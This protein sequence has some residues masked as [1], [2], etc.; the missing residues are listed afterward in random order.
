MSFDE[1]A[2]VRLVHSPSQIGVV[3]SLGDEIGGRRYSL[4][5]F[6]DGNRRI[7]EDQLELIPSTRE[8]PVD[9]LANG[10]FSGPDRYRQ[11]LTYI[12]LTGK[13][14]D[15]VYSMEASNT[16][17]YPYQF[18]PVLKML[19]SPTGGLLIADEVGLGKTIEAGLIWMELR[20]RFDLRRLLVICPLS[21]REKWQLELSSRFGIDAQ[22]A[23][24]AELLH[25]LE[26]S[27]RRSRGFAAI[28][29]METVLPPRGWRDNEDDTSPRARLARLLDATSEAE[30]L[31]DLLVIDEAHH[32]RNP[33]TARHQAGVLLRAASDY[34]LFLSATPIHLRNRDL[35]ALLSLLD[36]DTFSR[37]NEFDDI[38]SA[39]APLV[40]ARDAV[41]S[42]QVSTPELVAEI[43]L[44][45]Q[46]DLLSGSQQ[47][48]V[49]L[50][51]L[52]SRGTELDLSDRARIAFRLEQANLLAHV[53]SRTRRR[54][55][56]ELRIV[57]NVHDLRIEFSAIERLVY[58]AASHA[59]FEYASTRA[60][61]ERFLQ[62]TPQRLLSSSIAAAV[63]HWQR[64][65]PSGVEEAD[66]DLGEEWDDVDELEDLLEAFVN[67]E[68]GET[69]R[70]DRPLVREL[71]S[72]S[73]SLVDQA[74]LELN[75]SKFAKLNGFLLEILATEP[76][77]KLIIFSSFRQT[78]NYLGRR[79][80]ENGIRSEVIHGKIAETKQDVIDRFKRSIQTPV[81]LSSEVGSEGIDLQFCNMLINYDLPWNPMKVEQRIGRIDRLGQLSE[82]VEIVNLIHQDTIDERVYDRL[83]QRMDLCRHALGD[84]EAILGSEI[85]KLTTEFVGGELTPSQQERRL[86]QTARALENLRQEEER[87]ESDAAGL[88]AHGDY[89]LQ[90]V[91][92]AHELNRWV[93]GDDLVRYVRDGLSRHYP[94][95]QV[96][97]L[98][99]PEDAHEL[100]LSN[101][102]HADFVDYVER[103]GLFG[104]TRLSA[105]A[106][107]LK[108]RFS[109][110]VA[111][112]NRRG[113]EQISQVH[114]IVR[115]ISDRI[116][117][118]E[119]P[120][121]RPA[122]SAQ[123]DLDT[124]ANISPEP[125]CYEI[126]VELWSIGGVI[127]VEKLAY[128]GIGASSKDVLEGDMAEAIAITAANFGRF[129]SEAAADVNLEE[130]LI[131]FQDVLIPHM[132][133]SFA[134]FVGD[135]ESENNDR[136]AVQ[137]RSLERHR[138]QQSDNL[139]ELLWRYRSEGRERPARLTEGRLRAVDQ[140]Y[141]IRKRRI[142]ERRVIQPSREE[143]A[144]LIVSIQ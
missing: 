83:F 9:L 66:A 31:V 22:I 138:Q 70:G 104:S 20:A 16:D 37:Q 67:N 40:R 17:F 90:T 137:L 52:K 121:L 115:F 28:C 35:F 44:A 18:K 30:P 88:I 61:N 39:N 71:S 45:V 8:A 21:L 43:E 89:I 114:P 81:L 50:E 128:S 34:K 13:L 116:Q 122:V 41:L 27:G 93:S 130:S 24:P 131:R 123:L 78:L 135:R 3:L 117:S 32:L 112:R 74:E 127:P 38:L 75:D 53:V 64:Q 119:A 143:I 54:D 102:A 76:D 85:R 125:G 84:L 97:L 98:S 55:V 110:S 42:G 144:A 72:V 82:T 68:A 4:V 77:R 19:N 59:V 140:R 132:K 56:E 107:P 14:A 7:P 108:C 73:R 65:L 136:A 79:L 126:L 57:R 6:P 60:V 111:S 47:L 99:E 120:R 113:I 33:A 51:F 91:K 58:D 25:L 46:H 118:D 101:A 15:I 124:F 96:R 141:E 80:A 129:W 134:A 63:L 95:S 86:D 11:V 142:E 29:N 49:L 12:R 26:D 103:Q 92:A 48:N 87:L 100:T 139:G 1:N 133:D 106:V 2:F 23:N 62:A 105:R 10:R 109:P 5:Q 36:P 69:V 94:G